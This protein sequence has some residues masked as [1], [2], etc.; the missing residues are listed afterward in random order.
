MKDELIGKLADT[1]EKTLTYFDLPEVDL[2]KT[3]GKDKWSVRQLLHHLTDAETILYDRIRR[4]IAKPNQ[5]IWAFD[6]NAFA[7]KLDY[8]QYPLSL[9]KKVFEA[10]RD[11]M[12][13]LAE[14]HYEK[15]GDTTFIHSETGKRTLKVEFDKVVSHNELHLDHI[16]QALKSH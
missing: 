3:Y 11:S 4:V 7:E 8:D 14:I 16:R 15:L 5:V 2:N 10:I 9:N 12:I 1:K 13:Y 6:Q